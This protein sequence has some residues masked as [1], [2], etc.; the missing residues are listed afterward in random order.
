MEGDIMY[1]TQEQKNELSANPEMV[2]DLLADIVNGNHAYTA[3]AQG[4]KRQHRTL[5]ASVVTLMLN[6]IFEMSLMQYTDP[7]NEYAVKRCQE[8]VKAMD[9]KDNEKNSAGKP[10]WANVESC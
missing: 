2:M 7:R 6:T 9:E 4:L 5:Q 3:M 1:L 10:Y 8:I